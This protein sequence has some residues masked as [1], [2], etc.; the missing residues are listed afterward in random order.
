MDQQKN[1]DAGNSEHALTELR[2]MYRAMH[3]AVLSI[4]LM[5]AKEHP[6]T[7][8]KVLV[9]IEKLEEEEGKKTGLSATFRRAFLDYDRIIGRPNAS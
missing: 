1:D 2:E 8:D 3:L 4:L 5:L 9:I 7:V 6:E